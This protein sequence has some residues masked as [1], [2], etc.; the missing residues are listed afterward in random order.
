[1]VFLLL[2]VFFL[3][4]LHHFFHTQASQDFWLE[5][6]LSKAHHLRKN[7]LNPFDAIFIGSSRTLY[8]ISTDIF[9][10]NNLT[11]YNFGL[12]HLGL[13][14]YPFCVNRAVEASPK[15][16]VISLSITDFF[17]RTPTAWES[18]WDDLGVLFLTEKKTVFL[19]H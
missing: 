11:I 7:N 14:D 9:R 17:D 16:I 3:F 6:K 5:N 8:H 19:C 4:Y 15:A 2:N 13:Y 18:I 10:E 12:S 1:M